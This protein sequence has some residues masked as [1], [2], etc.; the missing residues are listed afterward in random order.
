MVRV[1]FGSH[2]AGLAIGGT[3]GTGSNFIHG[4]GDG[5]MLPPA[6][7]A[8]NGNSILNYLQGLNG[9]G[10]NV[11]ACSNLTGPT[12]CTGKYLMYP[13]IGSYRRRGRE[14]DIAV[15]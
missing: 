10:Q 4:W 11:G 8:A 1:A 9:A 13:N 5:N 2:S 3:F 12:P 6:I 7:Y 15:F 14:D